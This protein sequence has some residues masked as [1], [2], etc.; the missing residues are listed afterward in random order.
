MMA[1]SR[2]TT[3]AL[4]R[5]GFLAN[6]LSRTVLIGFLTGVGIQVAAGQLPAMLGVTATGGNTLTK[7]LAIVRS[8][9][10]TDLTCRCRSGSS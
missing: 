8:R 5:L 10:C 7:L 6:F 1:S 3:A 9:T 4:V 2:T